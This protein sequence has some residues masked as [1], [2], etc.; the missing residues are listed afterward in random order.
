MKRWKTVLLITLISIGLPASFASYN[1]QVTL[2]TFYLEGSSVHVTPSPPQSMIVALD[3]EYFGQGE[4]EIVITVVNS[5]EIEL[6]WRLWSGLLNTAIM[7][8]S[9]LGFIGEQSG[10]NSWTAE[11]KANRIII[12]IMGTINWNNLQQGTTMILA[13]LS[14]SADGENFI[15]IFT[16]SITPESE[17]P[18]EGPKVE[19]AVTIQELEIELTGSNLPTHRKTYYESQLY[20]AKLYYQNEDYN[21]ALVT[22][23]VA[24]EAL[25][26]EQA[27]YNNPFNMILRF[28]SNN[29]LTLTVLA[30]VAVPAIYLSRLWR[31]DQVIIP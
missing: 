11:T 30:L 13:D 23:Y 28:F 2:V 29:A 15:P 25:R 27:E 3:S 1:I 21:N 12:T 14:Y 26:V 20:K 16:F 6:T 17:E 22:A 19:A 9:D 10:E 24:L 31:K 4:A 7:G 8:Q 18:V 5:D